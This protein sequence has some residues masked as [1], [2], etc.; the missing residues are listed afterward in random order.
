LI[1]Q[2]A[3][4]LEDFGLEPTATRKISDPLRQAH[5]RLVRRLQRLRA[6]TAQKARQGRYGPVGSLM[7]L[8]QSFIVFSASGH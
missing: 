7:T 6:H 8:G 4:A 1:T 3:H 5:E 2:P